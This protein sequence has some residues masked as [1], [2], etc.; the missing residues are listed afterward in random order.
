[1]RHAIFVA[2]PNCFGLVSSLVRASASGDRGPALLID[3][4]PFAA[5][6]LNRA[7]TLID[8]A[9][10]GERLQAPLGDA[11]SGPF[12]TDPYAAASEHYGVLKKLV[13]TNG[14]DSVI[15][16]LKDANLRGMG[17]AGFPAFIK[18]NTVR[19]Q[20]D[21]QKYVVCN[22][23]ESEVGT[24]KD[25]E[26]IKALPH[27]IVESMVIAGLTTGATQGIIYVRHE[28]VQQQEILN[29]EIQRAMAAGVVGDNVLNT[30]KAFHLRV[31]SSPGGYI[32]GEET[33][34]LE[35][36]SGKRGHPRAKPSIPAI[37]GLWQ[38]PTL[39]NNVETFSYVPVILA[40]GAEWFR[41]QGAHGCQ[42]L[43]WIS[44]SGHVNRPGVFEVAMGTTYRQILELAGGVSDG[45]AL[46]CFAPSGP[47]LGLL[48]PSGLDLPAD[49]PR[50]A[51]EEPHL[52]GQFHRRLRRDHRVRRRH[53]HAGCRP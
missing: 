11:L 27:L 43:K 39:I 3:D 31:F 21:G 40:R 45:R 2:L 6:D 25:R 22:A 8:A 41:N 36:L 12:R 33:A 19:T 20:P 14:F 50:S 29:R 38:K 42:G 17:G 26:I 15:P 48:P 53:R 47:S 1:M 7:S 9:M 35:A 5:A 52:P 30:G 4:Q 44:V 18:W 10:A 49:F 24:F 32:Q 13:A 23:D 34:L 37:A 51:Q 46:K 16:A 28:Y